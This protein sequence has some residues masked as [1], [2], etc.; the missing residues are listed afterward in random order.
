MQ[1]PYLD[2]TVMP[3]IRDH[4]VSPRAAV[5]FAPDLKAV[6]WANGEGALLI[7][8]STIREA[9]EG[10]HKPDAVMMRQ[11]AVAAQ[12]LDTTGEAR[13][14]IRLKSG[15]KTRL[16][17]FGIRNITLPGGADA[18]LL[19]SDSLHGRSHSRRAMAQ[20]AVDGLDGYSHASAVLDEDGV[21]VAASEFFAALELD[22]EK[23]HALVREV[24]NEGDR[25]VKRPLKTGTGNRPAGIARL[26]DGPRLHL[27]VI[28]DAEAEV[29][30]PIDEKAPAVPPPEPSSVAVDSTGEAT[31]PAPFSGQ[32]S[33]RREQPSSKRLNRW[34]Y[35]TEEPEPEPVEF[36]S[37]D[38]ELPLPKAV[39]ESETEPAYEAEVS[40]ESAAEA[41]EDQGLK[42]AL[43][44]MPITGDVDQSEPE[45]SEPTEDGANTDFRFRAGASR[46]GL[47]GRWMA[48]NAFVS[49]SDELAAAVGPKS[50]AVKGLAWEEVGQARSL[51]NAAEISALLEKGDTWSGKTVLWPV[52]GTD[53]R[54][55]IDLA[56]LPSFDRNRSF[57]RFHRLRN[58][59]HGR[60][61]DRSGWRWTGSC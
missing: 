49:I 17:G 12:K 55:P 34:Y 25:L 7:G 58:H 8:A 44:K 13:A 40:S 6:L 45:H 27:L 5:L 46:S 15:F 16:L 24:E 3:D 39:T 32:F 57:K 29:A 36:L 31:S 19:I 47:S 38:D 42:V 18:V 21:V 59:T 2:V 4:V 28:A 56:G 11:I 33:K 22:D 30:A 1:Y 61:H 23:V 26:T 53:L 41:G 43:S 60:C 48:G 54:V 37:Y 50:A 14:N 20:M 35:K 51:A 10:T 52:Q 9:L